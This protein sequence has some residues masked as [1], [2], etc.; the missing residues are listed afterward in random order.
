MS[1]SPDVRIVRLRDL[2]VNMELIWRLFRRRL[3]L[4]MGRGWGRGIALSRCAIPVSKL[5][6]KYLTNSVLT[7]YSLLMTRLS[8]LGVKINRR[9]SSLHQM[10]HRTILRSLM[11]C[12][13]QLEAMMTREMVGLL[14]F[15]AFYR[16]MC[17]VLIS[18]NLQFHLLEDG[19]RQMPGS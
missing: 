10:R 6:Q 15:K 8:Q 19:A 18:Q 4:R 3:V 17:R 5:D 13:H 16:L 2:L 12:S 7:L 14:N 11:V 9:S 1:R